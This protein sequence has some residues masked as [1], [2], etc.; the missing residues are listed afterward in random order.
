MTLDPR[1]NAIRDDLDPGGHRLDSLR[2]EREAVEERGGCAACF[3]FR[4]VV[5]IG[6]EDR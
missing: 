3:R 2:I 1:L 5:G 6:G 4:P